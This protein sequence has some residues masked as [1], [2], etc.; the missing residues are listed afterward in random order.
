MADVNEEILEQ[1]LKVVRKWFYI[2]DIPFTVP[3]GYSNIDVL[4]YDPIKKQ[5]YDF[6]V[7]FRSAYSLANNGKSIDYLV[8]QFDEYRKER[9]DKL[10]EFIGERETIKVIVTTHKMVGKSKA[11]RTEMEE[12]F[13]KKMKAKKYKSQLWYFDEM[14]PELVRRVDIKGRYNTQLLQIIRMLE[15]Y[16]PK[17]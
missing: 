15:L 9:E 12:S 6:E 5:Y 17:E 11:K 7:K 3:R 16:K 10:R 1:Y 4:G 2:G 14:I 8:G 13:H